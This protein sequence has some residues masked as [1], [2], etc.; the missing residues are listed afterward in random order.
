M[1]NSGDAGG[2]DDLELF[3]EFVSTG[4]RAVRNQ[5]VER[6]LGLAIHIARRYAGPKLSDEDLKQVAVLGL[7]KAVDRFDPEFGAAFSAF[8]GQTIEGE[9]KRHFRDSGWMVRVPRSAQ[10]L[11]LAVRRATDELT[12]QNGRSPNV[13]EL[14]AHMDLERDEVLRGIAATA[15]RT[16]DSIEKPTGDTDQT[17]SLE[18]Q[19]SIA[20]DESGYRAVEDMNVVHTLLLQLPERQREIVR[21]RFFEQMSQADIATAVGI[22]QMHVSRLLQRSYEQMREL[23]LE[24]QPAD[25]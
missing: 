6:H 3:R 10:E 23:M 19:G 8:A 4:R 17:G 1:G 18:R 11:H 20:A 9:L 24:E 2:L 14:A 7:I 25:E 15:A 12:Q 21:L 13:E 16:V 5:L 22:S